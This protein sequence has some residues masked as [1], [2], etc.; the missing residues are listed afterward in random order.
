MS[1]SRFEPRLGEVL[2]DP[3]IQAVMRA[4]RVDP[5]ALRTSLQEM[6]WR[7]RSLGAAAGAIEARRAGCCA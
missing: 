5:E 1:R 3:V 4:D 6:A 7:L 2:A